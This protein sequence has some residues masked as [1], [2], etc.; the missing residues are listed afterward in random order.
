MPFYKV[1]GTEFIKLLG[2]SN[3]IMHIAKIMKY[4]YYPNNHRYFLEI[5]GPVLVYKVKSGESHRFYF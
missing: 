5:M 2:T 1:C 4:Y 3:W